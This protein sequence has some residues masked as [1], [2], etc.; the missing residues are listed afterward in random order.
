MADNGKG[1]R[2]FTEEAIRAGLSGAATAVIGLIVERLIK[3]PK[4]TS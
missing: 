1:G 2:S 4:K 3:G